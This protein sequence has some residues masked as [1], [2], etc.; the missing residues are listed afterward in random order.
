MISLPGNISK[1]L[2]ISAWSKEQGLVHSQD[3]TWWQN[4]A[5]KEISFSAKD[6]KIETMILLRWG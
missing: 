1:A 5:A 6:A 2:E 4:S 3:Y